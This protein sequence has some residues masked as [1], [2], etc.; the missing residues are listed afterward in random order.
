MGR[1]RKPPCPG[2]I[3]RL[4]APTQQ[5]RVFLFAVDFLGLLLDQVI[6]RLA[7]EGLEMRLVSRGENR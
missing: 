2:V 5:V 7:G 3:Q 1:R 4:S 6:A